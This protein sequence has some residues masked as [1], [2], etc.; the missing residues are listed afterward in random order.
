MDDVLAL[1]IRTVNAVLWTVVGLRVIRYGPLQPLAR[2]MV[3]VTIVFGMW[4]LAF[5]AL[6]RFD[7]VSSDLSRMVYTAFTAFA[8][9]VAV[10][11]LRD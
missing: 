8:A 11:I 1:V 9:M 4:A 2:K 3:N 5:G 7:I 10:A 6:V